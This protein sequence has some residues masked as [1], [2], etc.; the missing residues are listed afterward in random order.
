MKAILSWM[1]G[2]SLFKGLKAIYLDYFKVKR[3]KFGYCAKSVSLGYPLRIGNPQNVFLYDN[4]VL[5]RAT[6]SAVNAKFI[7]K[8][9]SAAAD[10]LMVRTGNHM[11]KVGKFYITIN[12]E[13]KINTGRLSEYDKD[14]IVEEDVWIG[15]NVTL[16][17]G[18]V[19]GRGSIVAAGAV[20]TKQF[21]P[22]CILGG[23]PAK[24]IKF[25][26]TLDEILE[27]ERILY[28]KSERLDESYLKSMFEKH[29][30][31]KQ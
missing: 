10:G 14:V 7:M 3:S 20:V 13:Y 11:M 22:Y 8:K 30:K 1:R 25:K 2:L 12:D 17:A 27:H 31:T 5:K 16:L 15:C 18:V 23:V 28:S 26:W 29:S 9:H 21:P 24:F 6:I 19:I 4:T